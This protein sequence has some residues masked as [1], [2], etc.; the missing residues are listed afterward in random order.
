VQ[1]AK[2]RREKMTTTLSPE[3][4]KILVCPL[5][6]GKLEYNEKT[7]ELISKEAGLAY[8]LRD[9]IPVMLEGEA[10]KVQV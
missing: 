5:T 2:V 3:L 8:P 4:L 10:R 6:K 1:G 9:G 7:N